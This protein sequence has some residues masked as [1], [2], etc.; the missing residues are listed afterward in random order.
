M[1]GFVHILH[2]VTIEQQYSNNSL[3]LYYAVEFISGVFSW[4]T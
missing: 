1:A 3:V 4:I 2:K